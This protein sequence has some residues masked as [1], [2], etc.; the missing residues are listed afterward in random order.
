MSSYRLTHHPRDLLILVSVRPTVRR[1]S[2]C[3]QPIEGSVRGDLIL[4]EVRLTTISVD[5][6]PGPSDSY[7]HTRKY[8]SHGVSKST[9]P[10]SVKK[11]VSKTRWPHNNDVRE[12]TCVTLLPPWTSYFSLLDDRSSRLEWG[13]HT[14]QNSSTAY[15]PRIQNL[16]PPRVP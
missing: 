6:Q 9:T 3:T 5:T 11:S 13:L 14:N 1:P 7:G 16:H 2:P 4:V 8:L 12:Y 10:K 15:H